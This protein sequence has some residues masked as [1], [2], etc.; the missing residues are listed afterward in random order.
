MGLITSNF[1]WGIEIHFEGV[2]T[3]LKVLETRLEYVETKIEV[4]RLFGG[5]FTTGNQYSGTV[6]GIRV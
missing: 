4:L 3:I 1:G 2:E 6:G 5:R